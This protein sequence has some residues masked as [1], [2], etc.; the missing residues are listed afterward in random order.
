MTDDSEAALKPG[1]LSTLSAFQLGRLL[2]EID[3]GMDVATE[4]AKD[5]ETEFSKAE[6]TLLYKPNDIDAQAQV[7]IQRGRRKVAQLELT[8]LKSRQSRIQ[9]I[10]RAMTHA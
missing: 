5:A 3:R 4:E 1:D 10:L 7:K 2:N 9:S 8:R 6:T